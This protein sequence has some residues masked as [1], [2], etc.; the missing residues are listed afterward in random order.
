MLQLLSLAAG[1]AV[2]ALTFSSCAHTAGAP[3]VDATP[4]Q[5]AETKPA[6]DQPDPAADCATAGGKYLG[7][8]KC[9]FPGGNVQQILIGA[10]A[11][12]ARLSAVPIELKSP[13]AWAM[14]T[15]AITF[16][17]NQ[18]SPDILGGE[19]ATPIGVEGGKRLLS[20]WWGVNNQEDLLRTLDWLQ[21]EGH[22]AQFDELGNR[23]DALSEQEFRALEARVQND[24]QAVN[25]LSIA[26][27]N[28]RALGEKGI[29]AWDLVRYISVCR[30]GYRAGYLSEA[31]AWDRIMPAAHRLQMTFASWQDLQSDFLIGR[32][33]WSPPQTQTHQDEFRAI[34]ERFLRDPVSPWNSNPWAMD[35]QVTT[36]LP[37][38]ANESLK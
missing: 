37:I 34:Y 29:L 26:R 22:R 7:D 35:L 9:E 6:T 5:R 16:E 12:R 14:A 27:K 20:D 2:A 1:L 28:H 17:F 36:A 8:M 18:D 25:Q 23:V 32:E 10:D 11:E 33:Y 4:A 19:A 3:P 15:T 30:W 21:F 24:P 13:H 31:E 38:K